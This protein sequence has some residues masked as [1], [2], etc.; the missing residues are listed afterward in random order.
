MSDNSKIEWTDASWNP[1]RGV[2]GSHHCVKVSPGCANCYAETMAA[3][4]GGQPYR[5][6][7]DTLRLDEAALLQPLRW[8]KARRIFVCSMTDL[9]AEDVPDAWIDRV[10]AVA[11]LCP[12]HTFQILTKRAARM[13]EYFAQP[14]RKADEVFTRQRVERAAKILLRPDCWPLPNVWLG[15][16]VED[17]QRADERIPHLLRTPAAVRW[18]SCEPLL[19]GVDLQKSCTEACSN[20][21]GGCT[22]DERTGHRIFQSSEDGGMWV[23]CICSRLNGLHWVVVGG[24]SGPKARPMH[25][26]WARS[27]R[28]QCQSAGVPFFF[29]QWGAWLPV[30]AMPER[31]E[32]KHDAYRIER[33]DHGFEANG[34]TSARAVG[35]G[36]WHARKVGKKAAGR[37]LDG[38]TWDEMPA[39]LTI[40]D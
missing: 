32:P 14:N 22:R 13:A 15:V 19:G 7:A 2:K 26:D 25:P 28:D 9:F 36:L 23:E 3:R 21:K 29:K 16:S 35:E 40:A 27:L 24:E 18:L 30:R 34:E 11:A 6:G 5:K 4:F 8:K 12:H 37:V 39:E 1:I 10:L 20:G 17:Q 38:R 33:G 31:K